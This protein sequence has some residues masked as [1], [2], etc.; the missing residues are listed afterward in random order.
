MIYSVLAVMVAILHGLL[1]SI[2]F[3]GVFFALFNKLKKWPVLEKT[4]LSFAVSM[5]VSYVFTG[6]CY[7]TNIEQWLW[8]EARSPFAYSGGFISHYLGLVGV[9][10][11]D[12]SVYW[13]LVFSLI[14]GL[15]SYIIRYCLMR[16]K[17]GLRG[18]A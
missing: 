14:L 8:R 7:L 12:D 5:I 3:V 15:G 2:L 9:K 6:G 4:Y 18:R 11:D 1:V 16:P 13:V 10:V 17:G